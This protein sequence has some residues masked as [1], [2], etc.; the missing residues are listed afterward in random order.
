MFILFRQWD[1]L[2]SSDEKN[3]LT[4]KVKTI[5]S[6][7][8]ESPIDFVASLAWYIYSEQYKKRLDKNSA[9]VQE[10]MEVKA[11]TS[12]NYAFAMTFCD[13][14]FDEF[15]AELR[16]RGL[17]RE[18]FDQYI[19]SDFLPSIKSLHSEPDDHIKQ[20]T[21]YLRAVLKMAEAWDISECL[22]AFRL[23]TSKK[24]NPP[25]RCLALA[26]DESLVCPDD[27]L[28][29]SQ[30]GSLVSQY[31][32]LRSY[33]TMLKNPASDL[34]YVQRR[35]NGLI[36]KCTLVPFQLIKSD[37][38]ISFCLRKF[39]TYAFLKYFDGLLLSS[40]QERIVKTGFSMLTLTPHLAWM[41]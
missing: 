29:I 22:N 9:T 8:K 32:G 13:L 27:N 11:R 37:V 7:R 38:W 1:H 26:N 19:T 5:V 18:G 41:M 10:V 16:E 35:E 12:R 28:T 33:N 36:R 20:I 21:R 40:W 34:D 6:D 4:R 17:T 2:L 23:V 30:F 31:G 14:I 15:E 39:N 25:G 24:T 3:E